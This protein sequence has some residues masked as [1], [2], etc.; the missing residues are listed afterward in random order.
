MTPE[1]F[2][3]LGSGLAMVKCK[4]VMGA[5]RLAVHGRTFAT[6]GWPDAG[7][8]VVKLRPSDRTALSVGSDALSPERGRRGSRGVTMVR[9]PLIGEALAGRVLLE[10]WRQALET[11]ERQAKAS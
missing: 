3:A 4:A 7:W 2:V 5:V 10:A 11:S 1:A 8:A 6:V 9:L